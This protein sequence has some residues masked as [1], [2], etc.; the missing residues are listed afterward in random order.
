MQRR[1]SAIGA[2]TTVVTIDDLLDF[3]S[4]TSNFADVI[5]IDPPE[6]TAGGELGIAFSAKLIEE[7]RRLPSSA[8][9]WDGRKWSGVPIAIMRYDISPDPVLRD[10]LSRNNVALVSDRRPEALKSK[11]Y[12]LLTR[13]RGQLMGQYEMLGFHVIEDGGSFYVNGSRNGPERQGK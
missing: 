11:L 1:L 6:W 12:A 9:M 13:Y 4:N 5:L 10:F 3:C 2:T 7:I 8:A